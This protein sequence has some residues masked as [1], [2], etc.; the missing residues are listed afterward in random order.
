[1]PDSGKSSMIQVWD[2]AGGAEILERALKKLRSSEE[3]PHTPHIEIIDGGLTVDGW[4]AFADVN[5]DREWRLSLRYSGY[6]FDR[7]RISRYSSIGSTTARR[8]PCIA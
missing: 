5:N 2:C 3:A 7:T 8:L 1:M 4:S 6:V